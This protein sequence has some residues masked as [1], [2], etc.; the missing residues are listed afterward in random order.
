MLRP[1]PS[2]A[3]RCLGCQQSGLDNFSWK[4]LL[5]VMQIETGLLANNNFGFRQQAFSEVGLQRWV[6]QIWRKRRR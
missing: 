3:V 2:L 4:E 6:P 1:P 5:E